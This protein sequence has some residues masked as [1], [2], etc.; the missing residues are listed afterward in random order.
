MKN[1]FKK[2]IIYPN[3]LI[4]ECIEGNVTMVLKIEKNGRLSDIIYYESVDTRLTEEA[5]RV[6]RIV[7]YWHPAITKHRHAPG[8]LKVTLKFTAPRK[9]RMPKNDKE[10]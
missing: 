1:F 3:E 5:I 7:G 10:N 4:N 9:Q 6:I 8:Y 2:N